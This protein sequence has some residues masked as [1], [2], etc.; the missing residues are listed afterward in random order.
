VQDRRQ[1]AKALFV[2]T[3]GFQRFRRRAAQAGL[4]ESRSGAVAAVGDVATTGWPRECFP[5]E[6]LSVTI[7][8][9]LLGLDRTR[10]DALLSMAHSFV[11]DVQDATSG[12][13]PGLS[14]HAP[15]TVSP[16][17]VQRVCQLSAAERF[18]V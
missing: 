3:D 5:A 8:L 18:P 11:M 9:E 15:Y 16:E 4:A 2:E 6:G 12:L 7:F 1:Q 10:E 17:L 13:R 14:P